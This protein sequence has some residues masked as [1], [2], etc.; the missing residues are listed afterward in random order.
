MQ[1]EER[2]LIPAITFC[3]EIDNMSFISTKKWECPDKMAV[4]G[5]RG[6]ECGR[7]C[8]PLPVKALLS[9]AF[10]LTNSAKKSLILSRREQNE[11]K[12]LA[13]P[14]SGPPKKGVPKWGMPEGGLGGKSGGGGP[15]PHIFYGRK[16]P[17]AYFPYL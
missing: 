14:K 6:K 13:T 1:W 3:T 5:G 2:L 12:A 7:S 15:S 8:C 9:L 4:E 10:N 16:E 17:V 11:G